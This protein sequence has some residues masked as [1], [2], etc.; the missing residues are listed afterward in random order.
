MDEWGSN[1]DGQNASIRKEFLPLPIEDRT[2]TASEVALRHDVKLP[3]TRKK[4]GGRGT[5]LKCGFKWRA[6]GLIHLLKGR[7]VPSL[8][9]GETSC[10]A[11]LGSRGKG[12]KPT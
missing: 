12:G 4:G 6:G 5:S 10:L 1:R 8:L 9:R 3:E 11:M 2:P 7:M